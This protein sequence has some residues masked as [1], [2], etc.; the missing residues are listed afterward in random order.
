MALVAGHLVPVA[1]TMHRRLFSPSRVKYVQAF[2]TVVSDTR[3]LFFQGSFSGRP[4]PW[5]LPAVI[6]RQRK[7]LFGTEQRVL[8]WTPKI[9]ASLCTKLI[10][11]CGLGAEGVVAGVLG[12]GRSWT[13]AD[14]LQVVRARP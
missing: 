4:V 7:L 9:V 2:A 5:D 11:D 14:E 13:D 8:R 12:E 1:G 10:Y 6:Q 3:A